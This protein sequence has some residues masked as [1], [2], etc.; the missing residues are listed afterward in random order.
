MESPPAI[1]QSAIDLFHEHHPNAILRSA[2]AVYNCMGLAFASRRTW[3]APD[4]LDPVLRLILDED[5]YRR[6]RNQ[7]ELEAGDL[8][9]YRSPTE[10]SVSHVAVVL[11]IDV[12]FAKASRN[13]IV[14]SKWGHG[15]EYIHQVEDVPYLLG[16]PVAYWTDR[17]IP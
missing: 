13:V 7:Q 5:D 4:S 14:V 2:T 11:R 8:V 1:I 10:D 3:V 16:A 15:G 9:I 17:R 12:D 6:L